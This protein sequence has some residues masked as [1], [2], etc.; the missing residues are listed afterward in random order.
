MPIASDECKGT[1]VSN[2]HILMKCDGEGC[3]ETTKT[4]AE[5]VVYRSGARKVPSQALT[6][7]LRYGGA[8]QDS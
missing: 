7:K 8:V 5:V 2:N 6:W 4:A 3:D 1:S